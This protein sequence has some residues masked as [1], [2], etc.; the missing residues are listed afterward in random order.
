MVTAIQEAKLMPVSVPKFS[1]RIPTVMRFGGVPMIVPVP[2]MLAAYIR[3][4]RSMFLSN[5]LFL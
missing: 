3:D 5:V 2:P 4:K 1:S